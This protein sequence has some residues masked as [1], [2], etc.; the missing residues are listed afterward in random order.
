MF[1]A[2]GRLIKKSWNSPTL[3]TWGNFLSSSGKLLIFTP[4]VLTTYNVD[5]I[6]FWYLL[7]TINSFAIVIDFGFYPTFSR[8]ISYVFNG[9]DE[10]ADISD[11]SNLTKGKNP[12]WNFMQQVYGTINST[13][14]L[15]SIL[16]LVVVYFG[17]VTSVNTIIQRVSEQS[18]LWTSY[19]IFLISVVLSFLAR[20][21]DTII[22]GT[23][24][25][26]LINRWNIINNVLNSISSILIVYFKFGIEWLAVN[27]LVFS[28]LLVV[29]NYFLEI[30]ICQKK[31][32]NFVFFGFDFKIFKWVWGPTWRSG[33]GILSS[34]GLTQVTGI[35][36][37]NMSS[38]FQLASYLITL[39]LVVTI[40]AFSRA[41]FYSKIPVF[42]GLR[43]RN[44][45]AQLV[46]KT[47]L[48]MLKSLWVFVIGISSL[49]FLG[50]YLLILIGSNTELE[51]P[52]FIVFMAFIWF[53]E[54][55]HAMHAQ[56]YSTTN[57]IPFYKMMIISGIANVILMYILV[58]KIGVWGFPT[59][60]AISN[61]LINN[62]WNVKIS[63]ASVH[64]K[65]WPFFK[66]SA[67]PPLIVLLLLSIIKLVII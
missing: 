16:V 50:E 4:L 41:P 53:F 6:A 25:V 39:K 40:S 48:A 7:L 49:F 43:V 57:K 24:H 59:S 18:Y 13:Y 31:F 30:Y 33:L 22:I 3:M 15:L 17:S 5:E 67:L 29:R 12:A 51:S 54:R 9:L 14:F 55:H 44:E 64:E 52:V 61:L 8:V 38:S 11:S 63:L 32:K 37:T 56:I 28:I 66:I 26:A 60:L 36:Y 47:R 62:W 10:V 20:R 65:F 2:V 58:P 34:T 1:Q 42:S 23:N 45:I 46:Q 21:S 35:I 27:Q 19:Y